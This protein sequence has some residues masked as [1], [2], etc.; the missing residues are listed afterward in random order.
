MAANKKEVSEN[1]GASQE[2]QSQ[3]TE[4]DLENLDLE[5]EAIDERISPSETNVF[6]K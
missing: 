5:V 1:E 3:E 2:E 6:D 4:L